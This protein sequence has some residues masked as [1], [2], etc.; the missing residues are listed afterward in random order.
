MGKLRELQKRANLLAKNWAKLRSDALEKTK[1][2]A[3]DLIADDQLF[4]KGIDGSGQ[5]LPSYSSIGYADF[6][7]TLNPNKVT[8]LRLSGDYLDGLFGNVTGDNIITD[9]TDS[10]AGKLAAQYGSDHL[11]TTKENTAKYAREDVLPILQ[12]S[13]KKALRL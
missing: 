4:E 7:A 2:I 9:S 6:K 13:T 12:D 5:K 11:S 1:E 8:D 3:L 10:K